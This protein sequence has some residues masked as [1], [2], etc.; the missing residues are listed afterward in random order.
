MHLYES[1]PLFVFFFNPTIQLVKRR[2]YGGYYVGYG[3]K[4]DDGKW[5]RIDYKD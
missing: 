3:L 4:R 5:V 1:R 2:V